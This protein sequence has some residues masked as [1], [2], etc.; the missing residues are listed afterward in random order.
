MSLP[1]MIELCWAW[2]RSP[3]KG[4]SPGAASHHVAH[5][6]PHF[7]LDWSRHGFS[8]GKAKVTETVETICS[9]SY[10]CPTPTQ[11]GMV[12]AGQAASVPLS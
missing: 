12:T 6:P 9:E 3:V 4:A 1:K 2:R 11:V 8:A 10:V 7:E 5:P